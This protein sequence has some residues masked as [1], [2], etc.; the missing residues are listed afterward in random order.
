MLFLPS[1]EAEGA[2]CQVC[3][4]KSKCDSSTTRPGQQCYL[5]VPQT[6]LHDLLEGSQRDS[7]KSHCPM[8][9]EPDARAGQ[10][11]AGKYEGKHAELLESCL[12]HVLPLTLYSLCYPLV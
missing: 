9:T 4:V 2:P 7:E 5:V 3:D 1:P 8:D 12:S 10:E 6:S 11:K